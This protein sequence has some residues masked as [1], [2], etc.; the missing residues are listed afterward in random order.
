MS[1]AKIK[2]LESKIEALVI[3]IPREQDAYDFY[4]ELAEEYEDK[5]SQEMFAYL[6]KQEMQH[7]K[8]L[9]NILRR[10]EL[11]LEEAKKNK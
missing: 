6:A 1:K 11:E 4:S 10:L 8:N 3:A 9:E 2:D 5:A 7:K